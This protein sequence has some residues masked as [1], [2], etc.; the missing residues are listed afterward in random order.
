MEE[1]KQNLDSWV[2][3]FY[4]DLQTFVDTAFPK[5]CSKC[6]K[7]YQDSHAFLTETTPVKDAR[8]E[9][10]SGLFVMEGL[11]DV[12]S[13]GV[14]RNCA[15]GSTL[16]ADY[17]DR[18]DASEKGN[19]RR[20]SFDRLLKDLCEQGIAEEDARSELRKLLRG[21]KSQKIETWIQGAGSTAKPDS[22]LAQ[23]ASENQQNA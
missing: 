20:Q 16:L 18:R 23:S 11:R 21:E 17:H 22:I 9:D 5:T 2:Q 8:L 15:C 10:R 12:A 3:V 4:R 13:I 19:E 6:G 14:F 1:Q 7:V